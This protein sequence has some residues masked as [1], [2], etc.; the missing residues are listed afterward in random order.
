MKRTA[1]LLTIV[2]AG[3]TKT[4][5]AVLDP[6]QKFAK[7]CP[8]AVQIFMTPEKV[9]SQYQEVAL[10]NSQGSTLWT[11]EAGML[12]SMRKKAA[13]VGANGIILSGI[14]E[15]GAM[16]KVMGAF[17]G[18]GTNRKGKSLAIFIPTDTARVR[19]ACAADTE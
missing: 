7:T 16:S 10:L 19:Q 13:A 12:K 11:K 5:A 1:L 4:N 17:L 14:D 9:T 6:T 18:T 15:P 2:L 8:N 3:C